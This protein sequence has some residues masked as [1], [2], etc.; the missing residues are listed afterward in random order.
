[1]TIYIKKGN[2]LYAGYHYF[3]NREDKERSS[4]FELYRIICMLMIVAHH[5]VVNSGLTSLMMEN[6]TAANT[7]YLWLFECG[8]KQVST[9]SFLL[10][11]TSCVRARS[12]LRN[13]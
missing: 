4:N 6:P 3:T 8:A 11:V 13:L 12:P 2:S 7:L 5:F 10:L 9:V 1:M